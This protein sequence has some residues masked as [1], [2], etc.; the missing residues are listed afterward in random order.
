MQIQQYYS[1]TIFFFF[2]LDDQ[3][4]SRGWLFGLIYSIWRHYSDFL[5]LVW[6]C[7]YNYYFHILNNIIYIFTHFFINTYIKNT[8]IIL[9][10]LLY[11]IALNLLI[12]LSSYYFLFL[13]FFI[14][15][16]KQTQENLKKCDPVIFHI[17]FADHKSLTP[18]LYASLFTKIVRHLTIKRS[19]TLYSLQ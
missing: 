4:M 9:L 14:Y 3:K 1:T 8:Q 2:F 6:Y 13:Y 11:Q 10:K 18:L 17:T 5:G 19:K 12:F 16:T 15:S 7:S